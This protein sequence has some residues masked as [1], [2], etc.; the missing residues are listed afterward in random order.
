MQIFD[1][2][3]TNKENTGKAV[4]LSPYHHLKNTEIVL[5]GCKK[6]AKH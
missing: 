1:F 2:F 4:V 5:M 3:K 6:T